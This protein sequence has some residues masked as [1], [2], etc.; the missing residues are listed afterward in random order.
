MRALDL[1]CGA[2]GASMGL[3]NAGFDVVGVDIKP[4]PNYPF[5]FHRADALAFPL[6]GFDLIWASPPCQAFTA[7]RR[8][9][10][11]VRPALNLIPATRERLSG[12]NFIIENVVGAP[13]EDPVQLCGSSFGLNIRRHRLFETSFNVDAPPCDHSWQT[14]RFPPASNRKN[15]RS[16]VE[17]GAWRVP[18]A[19][20][21]EAMGIDWM[22][23]AELSQAIPP[24]YS[25]FL[26]KEIVWGTTGTAPLT[27][28][29]RRER[30]ARK[31]SALRHIEK[32][33]VVCV[34]TPTAVANTL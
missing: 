7:Y 29:T 5:K 23:V 33:S 25:E 30:N 31:K 27:E 4:Q 2:G 24:A 20:Q 8:N 22:T 17:V 32:Q 15:L 21:Q 19:T 9:K 26:A 11:R 6:D 13:L 1:F 14:P 10:N 28:Q 34:G 16:T 18:L 3:Y 12:K